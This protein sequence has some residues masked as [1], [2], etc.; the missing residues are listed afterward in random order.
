MSSRAT[1]TDNQPFPSNGITRI[2]GPME[3]K[4][5]H[6]FDR[7]SNGSLRMCMEPVTVSEDGKEIGLVAGCMG[8]G[9]CVSIGGRQWYLDAM[10]LFIAVRK[11]DTEYEE[12]Y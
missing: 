5:D 6:D 8:G 3:L 1:K 2:C 10:E 12:T 7:F 11:L 4:L 9:I